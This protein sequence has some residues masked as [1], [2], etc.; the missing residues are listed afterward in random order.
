MDYKIE[1]A[2]KLNEITNIDVNELA[3]F[4]EIPPDTTLGDYAFPC[5]KLA[6]ELKKAPPMI[7]NEIKEKLKPD[8]VIEKINVVGGY[9]NIF[10]NKEGFVKSV[11]SEAL[12][13]GEDFGKSN[14]GNG[15]TIVIDYSSPNVAKN[16]HVGHLR[17]TIIGN[18]INNIYRKLGYNVVRINHLGDWGTQFG[19]LIVAYKKWGSKEAI[20][21]NG[22]SELMKIYVNSM[23]KQNMMT[24]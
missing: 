12:E 19:K 8:E 14:I 21:K 6:K 20:E 16:F 5:F 9:L 3:S 2:K 24:V 22:I 18:S 15:K 4:L 11:I 23:M 13:K 1:I 17:T 7:A 10:V